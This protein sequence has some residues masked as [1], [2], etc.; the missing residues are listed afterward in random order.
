MRGAKKHTIR[1]LIVSALFPGILM[2]LALAITG[3]DDR[4]ARMEENQV[5]LHA[6]VAANTRQLA[7]VSSQV[8][9]NNNE[10]QENIQKLDRND[11]DLAAG[12]STVQNEQ[13][14]L[15]EA[16]TSAGQTLDRRMTAL[17]ENQRHL[18]DGVTQV[19][20]ITQRT[21]SDVT[22]IARE[23]A[24]LHQMVQSSR[25]ELGDSIAVV[26]V[27]QEK[28]RTDLGQLRQDD[29]RMAE[30]LVALAAGQDRIRG[31]LD[32]LNKLMQLVSSD[33]TSVSRGQTAL[34]QALN[35]HNAAFADKSAVLEQNQRNM[36]ASM[37][38][39]AGEAKR[40]AEEIAVLAADQT[41][42]QQTLGANHE[43]VTGQVAAVIENQ[44][45]F[46][47]DIRGL[48]EKTGQTASQ[49]TALAT[50][51]DAIRET[52]MNDNEAVA[53]KLTGLSDNQ[54]GLKGELSGLHLKADTVA[55]GVQTVR[56][57]Q[58]ELRES[59]K[60]HHEAARDLMSQL[61]SGQ[62]QMEG[63]LD[64]LTSTAGQTALD[65]VALTDSSAALRQT[66]QA[67][68]NG[69]TEETDR[70]AAGLTS[71]ADRQTTMQQA[72]LGSLSAAAAEHNVARKVV[73]EQNEQI[74][75]RVAV[76]AEN[77]QRLQNDVDTILA[78]AGQTALDV[79]A[80][81]SQQDAL[82]QTVQSHDKTVGS[83][84]V[85]L[86]GAQEQVQ[87]GLDTVVATAGQTA[88]DVI[89]LNGGQARLAQVAQMDRQE[90]A[91]RLTAIVQSQQ[92]W[93]QRL[94]TAQANVQTI[95]ASITALQQHLTN[96][97][98]S[99]QPSLDGLT[100]Q[101]GAN[102]QGRAQFEATVDQDIQAVVDAI[103]QL[104]QDQASLVDQMQQIQK[105]TQ[106]QTKDIITAI[107]QLKQPPAEVK[108]SDSGTKLESSVAEAAVK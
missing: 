75:S 52:L 58:T 26:A 69:L 67:S 61:S 51:Q 57:E 38:G 95:A 65:V 71:V 46:Q 90:W 23:H 86:A 68:T 66:L 60:A 25:K 74:S 91:T 30:Q 102:G 93:A 99:L 107:Q 9:V 35:E 85:N 4:L 17:D 88:L 3:C 47:A 14:A 54:T 62:Q 45:G 92:Q 31:G 48:S 80:L 34:Q 41:V 87:S 43:I 100:S 55:S 19:A 81:A 16:V 6:M 56:T 15:H 11:T 27:N 63:Q 59:L 20:G 72:I 1:Q 76:A 7:T 40:N 50:G 98:G 21:A 70:I 96:L 94:D 12:I 104:R 39:I 28:T 37:D 64:V 83:R 2:A 77:Q 97:Q 13:G 103:S 44:Q 108:V 18:Q 36:Q 105:R 8:Y 101:L 22:A 79:I 5:R 49:L 84:M 82:R 89:A 24:T 32:G 73:T 106:S 33:V 10:V 78:T 29:Q 53:A 42:I